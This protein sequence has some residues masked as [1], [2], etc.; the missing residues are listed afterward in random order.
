MET[1]IKKRE[2]K[3]KPQFQ[4]YLYCPTCEKQG[5]EKEIKGKSAKHAESNLHTHLKLIH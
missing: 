3:D 2:L 5:I 1:K 4:F